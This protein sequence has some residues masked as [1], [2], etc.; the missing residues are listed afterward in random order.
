MNVFAIL[1]MGIL[2]TATCTTSE[3]KDKES[4]EDFDQILERGVIRAITSYS[5]VSYFIYRGLPM[6]YEYELINIFASRYD[7]DV[8]MIVARDFDHMLEM[9]KNGEGDLI[10]YGLT[11]TRDRREQVEFSI[12]LNTTRQVLV[13]R[14]PEGWRQMRL[15]EIEGVLIRSPQDLADKE[16]MVRRASSYLDRLENLQDEIGQNIEVI[17]AQSGITTEELIQMVAERE[18][19]FTVSDENIARL[20]RAFFPN[21][22]INTELSL[23]QQT[24][25][26]IRKSSPNLLNEINE[27]LESYQRDSEY[28]VIYN[29]YFENTRAFRARLSSPL[30]FSQSGNVSIYDDLIKENAERLGWDWK[31]LAALIFQESQFN[32]DARSWAGATGLMQLMPRTAAAY[33]AVN[34]ND[35]RQ[36]IEAGTSFLIWLNEYW[37]NHIEDEEERKNFVLASYNVGQGHVQDA[38]RLA[39][40]HGANPNVWLNNV[41][42][43]MEKKS[44]PEYYTHDVVRFGYARGLEPV[45]YVSQIRYIY[46]HYESMAQN[47]TRRQTDADLMAID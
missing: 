33:G 16:I 19:E 24:A 35:P 14:K 20:N 18:I 15:H 21:L 9:L 43:F 23:P 30:L 28:Y 1:F 26:A 5:P 41:A 40:Y 7:L 42:R 36:S 38:R 17:E 32:P 47:Q 4:S 12:P 34:T 3:K 27:W 46:S 6:G 22:D 44:N 8:E 39:E 37:E 2:F 45:R 25:W 13:Q 31:L 29:K 11:I 10:A